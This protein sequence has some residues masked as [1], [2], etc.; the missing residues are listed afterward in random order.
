MSKKSR[1][2]EKTSIEKDSPPVVVEKNGNFLPTELRCGTLDLFRFTDQASDEL[3]SPF[4]S[5]DSIC[6]DWR[7]VRHRKCVR[8]KVI[9]YSRAFYTLAVEPRK[10]EEEKTLKDTKIHRQFCVTTFFIVWKKVRVCSR[11]AVD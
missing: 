10:K 6:F 5:I 9:A 1:R 4:D 8:R 11:P 7:W 3:Q 2:R